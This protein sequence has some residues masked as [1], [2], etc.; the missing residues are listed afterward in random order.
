MFKS[1]AVLSFA[2]LVGACGSSGGGNGNGGGGGGGSD[3]YATYELQ[4]FCSTG[5]QTFRGKS[6]ESVA[7]AYC[8][9][10]I[11][12]KRNNNCALYQR[13]SLYKQVEC[14]GVWPHSTPGGINSN[15]SKQY[16]F[17]VN[18]CSTGAHAFAATNENDMLRMYCKG[19]R[20]DELNQN[21]AKNQRE[22]AYAE[23]KCDKVLSGNL[24]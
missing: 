12:D 5:R 3:F 18:G 21:C 6:E 2:F 9:A 19:L 11:D 15:S 20:D 23:N 24:E 10:L 7:T 17:S 14:R 4:G 16:L 13:Q 8:E 22:E 1:F